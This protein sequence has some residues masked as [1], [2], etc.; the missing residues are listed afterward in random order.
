MSGFAQRQAAI[1]PPMTVCR[2]LKNKKLPEGWELI[3]EVIEDFEQQ[4]KEAVN[5]EHEGKRKA[6]CTWKIHRIHWEKNRFIYDLM[7]VRKVMSRELVSEAAHRALSQGSEA[8]PATSCGNAWATVFCPGYCSRGLCCCLLMYTHPTTLKLLPPQYDFLVREKIADGALISKWRK[9]GYEILCST[10]A[11][12]KSNHNFGTTSHCRVPLKLRGAAQRIT[13]N[14]QTGCI[15]CASGDGK[16]CSCGSQA[17]AYQGV[18]HS[19]GQVAKEGS[20]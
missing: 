2:R 7:Y 1:S 18:A 4:M 19:R 17:P 3:E 15:S 8:S 12:N 14:V 20:S 11:I 13:P 10:L 6:E 16:V 9:P 5:E